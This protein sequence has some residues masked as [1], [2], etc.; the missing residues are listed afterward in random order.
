MKK[1]SI[2]TASTVGESHITRGRGSDD[3]FA[4]L[5]S[6]KW[7]ALVVCDG[8]GSAAR[9][10][11]GAD[12]VSSAFA[13]ELIKISQTIEG[14][15]PGPWL[16]DSIISSVLKVR[17][18]LTAVAQSFDLSEFHCTLVAALIS[19]T[20]G[21]SVHIGDGAVFVGRQKGLASQIE[22]HSAPENGEYS[23]ETYFITET[24][25][26]KNLRIRPLGACDWV[27][28]TTDGAASLLLDRD[29]KFEFFSNLLGALS[30]EEHL[31]KVEEKLVY[32]VDSDYAKDCSNDDKSIILAFRDFNALTDYDIE[33]LEI[34]QVNQKTS[35][36]GSPEAIEPTPINHYNFESMLALSRSRKSLLLSVLLGFSSILIFG[37]LAA[38][39]YTVWAD[40]RTSP[41]QLPVHLWGA[42]SPPCV[43]VDLC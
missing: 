13:K 8:A 39:I 9:S 22:L 10:R 19:D 41:M 14:H 7:S 20:G 38:L 36:T 5:Q 24:T 40:S 17:A 15:G 35:S 21:F 27:V 18:E 30:T 6:G 12:I 4:T 23:N 26:L 25:W 29:I 43:K 33:H 16:N 31:A 1:W 11:E 42:T 37:T 34:T 3:A 2:A 32:F 28:L